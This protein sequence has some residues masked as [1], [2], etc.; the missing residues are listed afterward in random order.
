M[1]GK[2]IMTIKQTAAAFPAFTEGSI[3]WLWFNAEKNGFGACVRKCG[4]KVLIDRDA[5]VNWIEGGTPT[6]AGK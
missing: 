6:A 2:N 4:K 3:R 5:F 1:D